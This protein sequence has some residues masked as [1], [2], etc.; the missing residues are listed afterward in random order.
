LAAESLLIVLRY[1]DTLSTTEA[2]EKGRALNTCGPPHANYF[3]GG[4]AF[5]HTPVNMQSWMTAS[6]GWPAV[7]IRCRPCSVRALRRTWCA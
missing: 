3:T 5:S 2:N 7:M 4:P 6:V 1:G